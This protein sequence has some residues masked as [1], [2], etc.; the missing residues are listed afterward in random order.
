MNLH[1]EKLPAEHSVYVHHYIIIF[2]ILSHTAGFITFCSCSRMLIILFTFLSFH[3]E[4]S[5]LREIFPITKSPQET[6]CPSSN[7]MYSKVVSG[8]SLHQ[9]QKNHK[10]P[11]VHLLLS[12]RCQ[13]FCGLFV[14]LLWLDNWVCRPFHKQKME[15]RVHD[16]SLTVT[17]S[18]KNTCVQLITVSYIVTRLDPQ[19]EIERQVW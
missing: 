4:L 6:Q 2:N 11:V 12:V 1:P 5:K 9:M 15:Q 3:F 10:L 16:S 13:V 7:Y 17:Q 14:S 18:V 19:G 8:I